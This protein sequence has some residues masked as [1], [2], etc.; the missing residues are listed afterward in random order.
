MMRSFSCSAALTLIVVVTTVAICAQVAGN[1]VRARS[2]ALLQ[3]QVV[4]RWVRN[5][6]FVS[7]AIAEYI[8]NVEGTLQLMEE[9]V[10][11]RIVGYP[12][13]PGWEEDLYVPFTNRE[14]GTN[15]YPRQA[16]PL[17]LDWQ[18]DRNVNLDNFEEHMQM[19]RESWKQYVGFVSS[20]PAFFYR[21]CAT[22]MNPIQTIP[23]IIRIAPMLT[24]M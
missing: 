5:S 12:D 22:R 13:E 7:E 21:E 2:N 14:T 16:D 10:L 20:S 18:I 9:V 17:P 8:S 19:H 24:T 1:R 6:R 23:H 4:A 3:Q 11:D 15:Q